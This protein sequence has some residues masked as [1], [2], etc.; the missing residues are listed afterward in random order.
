MVDS[1]SPLADVHLRNR[2]NGQVAV[3]DPSGFF[4]IYIL[5]TH[6][7][8]FTSV[9]YNPFY[10][11]I[12]GAFKGDVFYQKIVLT[13][14][15]IPLEEV[16][17][18]GEGEVAESMLDREIGQP[19]EGLSFGTLEGEAHPVEPTLLN[20]A[21]LLWEWF[22]KEAKEKKKLKQILKQEEIRRMIDDRFDSGLI[23]ELTGLYGN[24][25]ERFKVF[26][27]FPSSFVLYANEYDFLI[28]VKTCYYKY[29]NQ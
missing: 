28:A 20:P 15:T 7:I 19:I 8:R 23:W 17:I 3:S 22:S 18:Y 14:R 21:S 29:K 6:V 27:N 2:N 1:I 9:G 11:S 12:P 24:E 13:R 10:F 5:K 26:C 25:L 4:S 16:V